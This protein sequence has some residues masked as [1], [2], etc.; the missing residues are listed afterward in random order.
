M[1]NRDSGL[2]KYPHTE[3]DE[4]FNKLMDEQQQSDALAVGETAMRFVSP[5]ENSVVINRDLAR[6]AMDILRED[7]PE[8]AEQDTSSHLPIAN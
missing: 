3:A 6:Q 2:N 8:V 5:A 1:G 4:D 7:T